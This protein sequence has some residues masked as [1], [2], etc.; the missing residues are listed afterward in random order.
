MKKL[1]RALLGLV[2]GYAVGVGAGLALVLHLS[3]NMHDKSVEA[4]T[5]AAFVTGPIGALAGVVLGLC[6]GKRSGGGQH[7]E[8]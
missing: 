6:M 8:G 3:G 1:G 4:A 5:T 2:A 7:T